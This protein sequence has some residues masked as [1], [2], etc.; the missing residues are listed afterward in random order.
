MNKKYG[1]VIVLNVPDDCSKYMVARLYEHELWYYGSEET[2]MEAA[3]L[4]RDIGEN[5]LVLELEG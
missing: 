1:K 2:Y 5:S 4:S 3:K